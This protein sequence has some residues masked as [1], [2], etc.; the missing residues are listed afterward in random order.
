MSNA[1]QVISRLVSQLE[2]L[3]RRYSRN[4]AIY[5][6][7]QRL[8]EDVNNNNVEVHEVKSVTYDFEVYQAANLSYFYCPQCHRIYHI[9]S[10]SPG[11]SGYFLC[12]NCGAR[13]VQAY[14]GIPIP[15]LSSGMFLPQPLSQAVR[16]PQP[17][18]YYIAGTDAL[19]GIRCPVHNEFKGLIS[20]NPLRPLQSLRYYCVFNDKNCRYYG[21]NG[22]CSH[23]ETSGTTLIFP[24]LRGGH[25]RIPGHASTDV[26][27]PLSITVFTQIGSGSAET[28][29]SDKVRKL[30]SL[31][32]DLVMDVAYGSFQIFDFTIMYLLGAPYSGK[33]SRIPIIVRDDNKSVFLVR[34][35]KTEGILFKFEWDGINK[36]AENI[37]SQFNLGMVDEFTIVH[38]VSHVL[39]LALTRLTGL[40]PNEFGESIFIDFNNKVAEL[41]IYDN[42][43]QGIGG[44]KAAINNIFEYLGWI[45]RLNTPCPRACRT[46]CRAC[47]FY[48]ACPYL[49]TGLSWRAANLAI[50]RDACPQV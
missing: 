48:D 29:V 13:L 19:L 43:P 8:I 34:K 35:L 12:P 30:I 3:Q 36:L 9:N 16:R 23:T 49:N 10:I 17:N 42:S 44:V 22:T 14:V 39:L 18:D 28:D 24:P 15:N 38:S 41:L 4:S 5:N 32:S 47:V 26:T 33:F 25:R 45:C 27:K 11:S 46:A 50:N 7:L 31:F 40:S 2:A 6:A 37:K 1:M 21:T 20:T